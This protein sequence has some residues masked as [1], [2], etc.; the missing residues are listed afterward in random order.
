MIFTLAWLTC[1]GALAV[2]YAPWFYESFRIWLSVRGAA[3]YN[4]HSSTL[5]RQVVSSGSMMAVS[6]TYFILGVISIINPGASPLLADSMTVGSLLVNI[7]AWNYYKTLNNRTGKSYILE[8]ATL[9]FIMSSM[10][11]F[12]VVWAVINGAPQQRY[13]PPFLYE[14]NE[15]SV[16]KADGSP[17]DVSPPEVCAGDPLVIRISGTTDGRPRTT[18]IDGVVYSY[19]DSSDV[20]IKYPTYSRTAVGGNPGEVEFVYDGAVWGRYIPQDT[21]PGLYT[22]EHGAYEFGSES[23]GF[24]AHFRV[25]DC[26]S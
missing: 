20:L 6:I 10:M 8:N 5:L 12:I 19:D 11:F 3:Q 13:P 21:A 18:F 23:V 26:K 24:V 14:A 1:H 22:Y 2:L 16:L 17:Q 4:Q 9:A 25:I 7:S 15:M